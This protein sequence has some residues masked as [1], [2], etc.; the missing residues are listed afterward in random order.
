Y[1]K[2]L[3]ICLYLTRH[4]YPHHLLLVT[5]QRRCYPILFVA[6]LSLWYRS[7]RYLFSLLQ[8]VSRFLMFGLT[9]L[10]RLFHLVLL[11]RLMLLL[12]ISY[13]LR[14]SLVLHSLLLDL[15]LIIDL[16]PSFHYYLCPFFL[17]IFLTFY[18]LVLFVAHLC[19]WY[20]SVRYLFSL[21]LFVSSFLMFELMHL[22][23]LFHLVLLIRLMLL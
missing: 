5:L 17:A 6:H 11:I 20:R 18:Y 2:F 7:V 15:L 13:Q 10:L 22:L 9:H 16:F 14:F 4:Y 12:P 21:L 3:T 19:L 1:E 23:R 8:F